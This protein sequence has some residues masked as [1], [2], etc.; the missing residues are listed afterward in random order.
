MHSF[1]FPS[2]LI[3]VSD[4]AENVRYRG[5]VA[6]VDPDSDTHHQ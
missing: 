5:P 6:V 2:R 1:S 4:A 3:H